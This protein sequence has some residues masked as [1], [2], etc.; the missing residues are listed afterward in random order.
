MTI[1]FWMDDQHIAGAKAVGAIP[2]TEHIPTCGLNVGDTISF[3]G[4]RPM[5]YRVVSRHYRSGA[6]PEDTTW[7]IQLEPAEHPC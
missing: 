6:E 7:L 1:S 3:P 5:A 2:V 4:F